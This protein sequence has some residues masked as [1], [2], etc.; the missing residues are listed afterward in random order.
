FRDGSYSNF[1]NTDLS[2][3]AGFNEIF[4][5]FSWYV[6]ESDTIRYK[7]TGTHVVYDVGG[8]ADASSS[9]G[10]TGNPPC[11]TSS[12]GA[13]LANTAEQVHL[14]AALRVPGAVYCASAD[15][16][17]ANIATR[18]GS[19]TNPSAGRVD[20]PGVLTEG[21]QGFSGQNSFIEFGKRPYAPA[22]GTGRAENGGI[23]GEGVYASTRPFDDPTLLIH[24]SWTPDVP[25]VTINLYQEGFAADGVTPTLTLVDH[26]TTSSWDDWAQGFRSD[27]L[28]NI[29]CPGQGAASGTNADLFFFT[30]YNQPNYLDLYNYYF[31]GGTLHSL[32]NNSQYKCYDGMHNWNQL[33]PAPYDGVYQFPSVLGIVPSGPNAGKL[34]TALNG[35]VGTTGTSSYTAANMGGT[36][37]T[38]C[39]PDPDT[40]DPWR[41]GTPMLPPGKYVV[42]VVPPPGYE[43]E[44]EEDKNLL[45]GDNFI[46]PVTN[47]FAGLGGD[48]FIIPDQ[49]SVASLY[50]PSGAGSN[51]NNAQDPTQSLGAAPSN[52]IVP[53]FLEPVQPCVGLLRIVPDYLSIFP[54]AKEVAS[55]AGASRHLCDRKEV[56]L[57]NQMA[58]T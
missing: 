44:K 3:N 41:V 22:V 1:N 49:A 20:P 53:G 2:G 45:I 38:I 57:P 4:P 46:A 19:V 39:I 32:P 43:I 26:T 28:P 50:D 16:T 10:G 36:N 58:A 40:T 37:C 24:T 15:C 9:C 18:A 31:N 6:V 11:G 27:G 29:N 47:Q 54:Q 33:Q 48:I 8:P 42:E 51:P 25:G 14:P 12:I 5:L 21:W 13:N 23:H 56:T 34:N 17:G 52:Q 55:F 35:G 30:L 7:N